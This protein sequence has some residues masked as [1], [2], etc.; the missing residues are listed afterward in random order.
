M[1]EPFPLA[2]RMRARLQQRPKATWRV[3]L[4][5]LCVVHCA[6]LLVLAWKS[7][8]TIDEVGHLGAGVVAVEDGNIAAYVVN[9]PLVRTIAAAPIVALDPQLTIPES[10]TS[11][12][13]PEAGFA[14]F[15]IGVELLKDNQ[16]WWR[17]LV[18]N[19]R[20]ACI[21]FSV[22]GCYL[23]GRWAY[24]LL[25]AAAATLAAAVWCFSP[26]T[27][28][29]GHI[30]VPD[31][32]AATLC[33][34]TCYCHWRWLNSPTW[35]GAGA[36]SALW[37][38]ACLTKMTCVLLG[39]IILLQWGLWR[40]LIS[41][42]SAR[43]L[44]GEAA[45]G[46]MVL[47]IVLFGINHAYGWRG[48][49][50]AFQDYHFASS[51]LQHIQAQLAATRGDRHAGDQ[52]LAGLLGR[53]PVP[54]PANYVRGIDIQ[55][56][57][58]EKGF[59]SFFCGELRGRGW[60]YYYL[61]GLLIK[62]PLGSL[63]LCLLGTVVWLRLP[64]KQQAQHAIALGIPIFVFVGIVSSQAGFSHHLRYVYP[65]LPFLV[66]WAVQASAVTVPPSP[67][68]RSAALFLVVAAAT[69]SLSV[70]P[71]SMSFFNLSIGGPRNGF[72][73]MVDSNIDWGQDYWYLSDWYKQHP[74]RRPLYLSSFTMFDPHLVGIEY[75]DV[76]AREVAVREDGTAR[77]PPGWYVISVHRLQGLAR[78]SACNARG[79]WVI[80]SP[81][82][83]FQQLKP[84][85][86]IG[87]SLLVYHV[88]ECNSSPVVPKPAEDAD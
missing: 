43:Q 32:P 59:P 88:P 21:P 79:S 25:G 40:L 72:H 87:Y 2:A 3:A 36:T 29:F 67:W 5:L 83:Y 47:L 10:S 7:T 35:L 61:V 63:G 57:H 45:Q 81:P 15:R 18:F 14:G 64:Q 71:H 38:L 31:I 1:F 51:S 55:K 65:A 86:R 11:L 41:R 56:S 12:S 28:G 4:V 53:V 33:L 37:C 17:W 42:P 80:A 49:F 30:V 52:R 69:E 84:V 58:F 20:L 85:D 24:E 76:P 73:Y 62:S 75:R 74:E 6:L 16:A 26:H 22:L 48:S 23:V 34:G 66:L 44:W 13:S 50:R 82:V 46:V 54:L 77:L 8:P 60:W 70:Y 27:L 19:A 39:P 9:P 78:L 68:R